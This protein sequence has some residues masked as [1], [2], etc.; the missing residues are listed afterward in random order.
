MAGVGPHG[1]EE[2][3]GKGKS[4]GKREG[5]GRNISHL[6]TN[7]SEIFVNLNLKLVT[8]HPVGGIE[9][10]ALPK[11]PEPSWAPFSCPW[12]G[13]G[14]PVG[15]WAVLPLGCLGALLASLW[16][17]LGWSWGPGALLGSL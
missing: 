10:G 11:H 1:G 12:G 9:N 5:E 17:P 15:C 13:L 4:E 14:V 7:R 2:R 8:S 6:F 3:G 16:L